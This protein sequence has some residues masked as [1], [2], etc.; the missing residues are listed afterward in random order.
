MFTFHALPM[1]LS[2]GQPDDVAKA[3]THGCQELQLFVQGVPNIRF[4]IVDLRP[5][6]YQPQQVENLVCQLAKLLLGGAGMFPDSSGSSRLLFVGSV[7]TLATREKE[8]AKDRSIKLDTEFFIRTLQNYGVAHYAGIGTDTL[9]SDQV[10]MSIRSALIGISRHYRDEGQSL[11]SIR[12]NDRLAQ[13]NDDFTSLVAS[14]RKLPEYRYLGSTDR[15]EAMSEHVDYFLLLREIGLIYQFGKGDRPEDYSAATV[16]AELRKR[17][18]LTL[19]VPVENS[20][21]ELFAGLLGEMGKWAKA[22]HA[23]AVT[24]DKNEMESVRAARLLI[25]DQLAQRSFKLSRYELLRDFGR[26]LGQG[27]LPQLS[28][29]GLSRQILL[30]DDE[31]HGI[32]SEQSRQCSLGGRDQDPII[33]L[34]GYALACVGRQPVSVHVVPSTYVD[35]YIGLMQADSLSK[36]LPAVGG[37]DALNLDGERVVMHRGLDEYLAI[38][39]DPESRHDPCGPVRVQRLHGFLSHRLGPVHGMSRDRGRRFMPPLLAYSRKESSG[40][41]QQC[42][43]MGA[44]AFVPKTRPYQLLFALSRAL[45]DERRAHQH[46]GQASQFRIL[47]TL[48]PHVAAKLLRKSGPS[49]IHGGLTLSPDAHIEDPR[50]ARWIRNLPKA[51]LHY[52][53][54]TAIPF[55]VVEVLAMNT[56][57]H[58]LAGAPD[59]TGD[60]SGDGG[61]SPLLRKLSTTLA[62]AAR[63]ERLILAQPQPLAFSHMEV[64]AAAAWAVRP[65]KPLANTPFGLGDAIIGHL[66]EPNDRCDDAHATALFVAMMA[67]RRTFSLGE[68]LRAYF[69]ELVSLAEQQDVHGETAFE[70]KKALAFEMRRAHRHFNRVACR[71]NGSCTQGDFEVLAEAGAP[72]FWRQVLG[73]V[74]GRVG[75]ANQR[76]R[77]NLDRALIC[78]ETDEAAFRRALD[79]LAKSSLSLHNL[80]VQE[81]TGNLA[82]EFSLENFVA[83][84]NV[85]EGRGLQIYLRGADLLG[86]SHLQYP[87]NLW[88]AAFAITLDNAEQNIIYSE[89]RCETTGYT[90]AGMGAHDATELLRHGFNLASLYVSG[91]PKLSDPRHQQPLVRTNILLAAKR[92]KTEGEARSAINLL[93]AYLESRAAVADAAPSR[94]SYSE[95]FGQT[96]PSWWRPCDVVGFDL[97]GDESRDQP[98]LKA[99]IVPLAARS[100]PVTIH[101]GEAASAE[102]I[103]RA[104]YELNALRIGHGL[105]LNEDTALLGYC[106]REGICME[107]CPNSNR[108]TNQLDPQPRR[109]INEERMTTPLRY[110]YPLLHYLSQGME[111]TLGTDNR[112]LHRQGQRTLTSEYLTAAELVGGLTR[113]EV[114]QIVKAGFKNAFLD[115]AEVRALIGAVEEEIYRIVATDFE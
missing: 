60:D 64:L 27:T 7:R 78:V 31:V 70:P 67:S 90:K 115:K 3:F 23:S 109:D 38:L 85:T 25:A 91:L 16:L 75:Q 40:Y 86:S 108:Y 112:Y 73:M 22:F 74:E 84:P 113:W 34:L 101:A 107:F 93:G 26:V 39:I 5:G 9:S 10:A 98:W 53:F 14:A 43:N 58:F 105:R 95:Q 72:D 100:S 96:M 24:H 11:A 65:G 71:W 29:V 63:L 48:K 56:A 47:Q 28:K 97:S 102:S 41:V 111:V 94:R 15:P 17:G 104:V 68:P 76:L 87:E 20:S 1:A 99:V 83:V 32:L 50:E 2:I 57:G 42:L 80:N 44:S 82:D 35:A 66:L 21:Y 69:G 62:V 4:E 92:H 103:W 8:G 37:A 77:R 110:E 55:N 52:H 49:F 51:D 46:D 36:L 79:W 59:A 6:A 89:V 88:I 61:A 81:P 106:V 12:I 30:V 45:R 13:I 19:D 33:R 54:G 18:L 114:L